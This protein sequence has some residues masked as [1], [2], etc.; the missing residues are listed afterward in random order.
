MS[1]LIW[2]GVKNADEAGHFIEL[3]P[4]NAPTFAHTHVFFSRL[5][6]RYPRCINFEPGPV[7]VHL[8]L[9]CPLQSVTTPVSC[10]AKELPGVRP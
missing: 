2:E 3:W 4:E 5:P 10:F 7:Q 9:D 8:L 1:A 6:P